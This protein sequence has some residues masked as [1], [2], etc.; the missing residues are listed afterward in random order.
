MEVD[1]AQWYTDVCKRRSSSTTP[2]SRVCSSIA[3]MAT[4]S[5]E[6]IQQILDQ[7]SRRPAH[8]NVYLPMLIPESLLQKE[9]DHVEGFAP[10]APGSPWAAARSWRSAT[11]SVPPPRP[12][13]ASTIA[14]SST[15]T[16]TCPSCTTSG[17]PVL[18]WEKTTRPFLRHREFLWQ[19]GHTMHAT[20]EEAR[21]DHADAE[22]LCRLHGECLAMPVVRGR[23]TEKEKFNGAGGDLYRGV[24]DA[25]PEGPP[26]RH[27]P[28]LSATAL[29]G[30][31]TSP[32]PARTTSSHPPTRPPGACPPG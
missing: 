11:A 32:S 12:C 28:L 8:E 17:A 21:R 23:K 18:R 16:G 15:P 25:R 9:K 26:G 20:A 3:P 19:E 5:G 31:L 22:R 2:P 7:S 4:P 30:P 27:Q 29:P 14:T 1:F 6:N 10:S 13:S 24:H